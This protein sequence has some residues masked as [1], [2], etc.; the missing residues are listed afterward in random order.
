MGATKLARWDRKSHEEQQR[1]AMGLRP[2]PNLKTPLNALRGMRR[3]NEMR[4]ER[5]EMRARDSGL[6][7]KSA[8]RKRREG[9]GREPQSA[10]GED[11][12]LGRARDSGSVIRV[13]RDTAQRLQRGERQVSMAKRL[14]R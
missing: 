2:T 14:R 11:V 12:G 13:N 4:R 10:G 5:T 1:Q 9:R 6:Q 7:V 3:K 8:K